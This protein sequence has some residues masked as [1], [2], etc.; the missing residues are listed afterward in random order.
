MNKQ[1]CRRKV[2]Y[3]APQSKI[4]IFFSMVNENSFKGK[5]SLMGKKPEPPLLLLITKLVCPY[6]KGVV[7]LLP[8]LS[9]FSSHGITLQQ[10]KMS[11]VQR[12][13]V[14]S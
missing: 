4:I 6:L 3:T 1:T 9:T 5:N 11:A 2:S 12:R 10:G 13:L 8:T 7:G 14:L